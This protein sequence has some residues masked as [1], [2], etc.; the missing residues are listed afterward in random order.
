MDT[1]LQNEPTTEFMGKK[2]TEL[3]MEVNE[4]DDME[5]SPAPGHEQSTKIPYQTSFLKH[6]IYHKV[7]I[8][9]IYKWHKMCK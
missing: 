3:A 7:I 2:V 4:L 8:K 1:L 6:F 5:T 9:Q